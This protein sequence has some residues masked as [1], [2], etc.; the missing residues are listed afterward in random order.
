VADG[1][2]F[3]GFVAGSRLDAIT[4]GGDKKTPVAAGHFEH[5]LVVH[6]HDHLPAGASLSCSQA[7][8]LDHGALDDVRRR[9]LHR[10]VDG[11]A[12]RRL[13]P[14]HVA[15]VDLR[16]VQ[17]PAEQRLDVTLLPGRRP[18]VVHVAAH[19]GVAVE[20]QVDVLLRLAALDAQLPRESEGRHAVDETEVDGLGAAPLVRGH[21]REVDAEDLRCRGAVHVELLG[22]SV[23]QTVRRPTG[24]P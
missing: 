22:E 18:R 14:L 19:A 20:I 5:Q 24:A 9:A 7:S 23:L 17:A 13:A 15:D 10:R 16:Q 6:L 3:G 12:L 11:R 21:R 4:P 8:T 2:S 1:R